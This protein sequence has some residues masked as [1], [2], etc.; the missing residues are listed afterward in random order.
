M[1]LAAFPC[2]LPL[3]T[4]GVRTF[5]A[6]TGFGVSRIVSRWAVTLNTAHKGSCKSL[7]KDHRD[8]D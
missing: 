5:G 2:G 3:L 8:E 7:Y 6:A 4:R 1:L